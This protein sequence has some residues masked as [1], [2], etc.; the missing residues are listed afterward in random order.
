MQR[1]AF[2]EPQE[3][4]WQPACRVLEVAT[5]DSSKREG[6]DRGADKGFLALRPAAAFLIALRA[7]PLAHHQTIGQL[8]FSPLITILISFVG[9]FSVGS[10]RE[11]NCGFAAAHSVSNQSLHCR[12][13]PRT[14][15]EIFG[16]SPAVAQW[17]FFPAL[18]QLPMSWF[19]RHRRP[20]SRASLAAKIT[21]K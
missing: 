21:R 13:R 4:K 20:R 19:R 3:R 9:F 12:E 14:A 5:S 2:G 10:L 17:R 18:L 15:A 1:R 8:N 11:L 7:V 16:I 6:N